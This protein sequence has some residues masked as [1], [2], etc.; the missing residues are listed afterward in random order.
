MP[1]CIAEFSKGLAGQISEPEIFQEIFD[2]M[3]ASNLF[4]PES[5]KIRSRIYEKHFSA[6]KNSQFFH[7][8][9]RILSGRDESDLK[10]LSSKL[11]EF[12]SEKFRGVNVSVDLV[13]MNRE[14]YYKSS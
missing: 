11:F 14:F 6:S 4:K 5:I 7:L 3:V 10:M 13:E 2:L 8:E 9:V 1:H 12:L